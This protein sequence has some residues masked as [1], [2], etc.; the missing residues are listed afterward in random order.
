M[1]S[2]NLSRGSFRYFT[3][4]SAPAQTKISIAGMMSVPNN[5][6]KK[7]PPDFL[8]S[9]TEFQISFASNAEFASTRGFESLAR[10]LQLQLLFWLYYRV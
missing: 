2:L 4:T 8:R 10:F 1:S 7:R 6:H 5:R 9:Q 3:K